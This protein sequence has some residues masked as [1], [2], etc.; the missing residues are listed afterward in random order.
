MEQSVGCPSLNLSSR[1]YMAPAFL[2]PHRHATPRV[3]LDV[4]HAVRQKHEWQR[5]NNDTCGP[6][7]VHGRL[8]DA[9]SVV[10]SLPHWPYMILS[11]TSISK[12]DAKREQ[13]SGEWLHCPRCQGR[14]FGPESELDLRGPFKGNLYNMIKFRVMCSASRVNG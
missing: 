11:G 14:K 1:A 9:V 2:S 5:P 13:Y 6:V 10:S 4:I 12:P 8:D 3:D 7:R